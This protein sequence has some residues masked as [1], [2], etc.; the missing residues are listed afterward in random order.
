[1]RYTHLIIWLIVGA[2]IL[3]NLWFADRAP[4]YISAIVLVVAYAAIGY[5][6][7]G[8]ARLLAR[9]RR[10]ALGPPNL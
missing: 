10:K 6:I 3:P 5:A 4:E 9:S 8:L 7:W 2:V 1:M